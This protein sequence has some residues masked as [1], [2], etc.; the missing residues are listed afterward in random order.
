MSKDGRHVIR[1]EKQ[2]FKPIMKDIDC[3][4]DE[5]RKTVVIGI[6]ELRKP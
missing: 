5:I 3:S 4:P 1:I 2:G 6:E